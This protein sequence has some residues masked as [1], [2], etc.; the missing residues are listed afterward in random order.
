MATRQLDATARH[1]PLCLILFS[2]DV[3]LVGVLSESEAGGFSC[4]AVDVQTVCISLEEA[5]QTIRARVL[6]MQAIQAINHPHL[7]AI[8]EEI[9]DRPGGL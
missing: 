2:L 8:V 7:I 9:V 4:V 5:N 6:T 3:E 1:C